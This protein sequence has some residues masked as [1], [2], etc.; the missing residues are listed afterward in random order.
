MELTI[1]FQTA[2]GDGSTQVSLA[3]TLSLSSLQ[4]SQQ[5]THH[6][7]RKQQFPLCCQLSQQRQIA[8][9]RS[10]LLKHRLYFGLSLNPPSQKRC[11]QGSIT[12]D[13]PWRN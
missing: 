10:P 3:L 11:H 2:S 5:K 12:P 1:R 4:Q 8:K 7:R 6:I 9:H 13:Q